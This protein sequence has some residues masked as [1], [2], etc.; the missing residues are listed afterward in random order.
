MQE[1]NDVFGD[2]IT[3]S[4]DGLQ[5]VEKAAAALQEQ[6]E[7]HRTER[8]QERFFWFFAMTALANVIVGSLAPWLPTVIFFLFSVTGLVALAS[9]LEV[10]WIVRNLERMLDSAHN[11]KNGGTE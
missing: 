4:K 11:M 10:P 5:P 3:A 9:W 1:P 8:K 2:I 7:R 6:L